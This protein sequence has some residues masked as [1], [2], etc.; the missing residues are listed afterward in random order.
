MQI[1]FT[2]DH[3]A[4]ATV[5]LL[6]TWLALWGVMRAMHAPR[7]QA[8][9]HGWR[10]VVPP[11]INITGVLF[12]LTLA[13][14]AN[15][16]W[17]AHDRATNA[18]FREA[19]ALRS[20]MVLSERVQDPMLRHTLQQAL[21]GYAHASVTEWPLLAHRQSS[22]SVS[23]QADALLL[24]IGSPQLTEAAGL[25]VQ[26]L[27]L[28]K[29]SGMRD[30]RNLRIGLSQIHINPLKWLAMAFLGLLT[31]LAIALVHVDHPRAAVAAMVLFA[32]SA[33]P[34]AAIVLV[35]GNPFQPPVAVSSAPLLAAA[36]PATVAV[37]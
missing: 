31:L 1:F 19:D 17:N 5:A 4:Y 13:F 36:T 24:H 8:V 2:Y 34:T 25:Q 11:F 27:M 35:Q 14:V 10:G 16:T 28:Q 33:A 3:Y 6:G 29:A 15:D 22:T 18:V 12:G 26:A 21:H 37:P 30:E 9:L 20:L 7:W 23:D 32:L